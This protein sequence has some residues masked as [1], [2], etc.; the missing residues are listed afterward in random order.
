MDIASVYLQVIRNVVD[1][2]RADFSTEQLDEKA[3]R[4]LATLWEHKLLNSGALNSNFVD[5]IKTENAGA[6]L[7]DEGDVVTNECT[8]K[9]VKRKAGEMEGDTQKNR[10]RT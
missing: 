2:V 4:T 8:E 5:V 9:G 7:L 1:G 6:G 3:L 10:R